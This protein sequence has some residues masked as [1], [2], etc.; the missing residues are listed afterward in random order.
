MSRLCATAQ[1]KA[2]RVKRGK[3]LRVAAEQP[4]QQPRELHRKLLRPQGSAGAAAR[5]M[6]QEGAKDWGKEE[7][8]S[9]SGKADYEGADAADLAVV[10]AARSAQA[11]RR[12]ACWRC[13]W[14]HLKRGELE[15][16]ITPLARHCDACPAPKR[17]TACPATVAL[18]GSR[19]R[20]GSNGQS[21]TMCGD[22]S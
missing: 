8:A 1:R 17:Q 10:P 5:V 20:S 19:P 2:A 6:K 18:T 9:C 4:Q 22:L 11:Q 21:R 12:A 3:G 14:I 7:F 13:G 15:T 16:G